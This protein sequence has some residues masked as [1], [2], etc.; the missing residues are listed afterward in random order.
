MMGLIVHIYIYIFPGEAS[1][2]M[3]ESLMIGHNMLDTFSNF[4]QGTHI[5]ANGGIFFSGGRF[6]RTWRHTSN[7]K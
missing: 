6:S 2:Q 7:A 1:P 5:S 3:D 4:S